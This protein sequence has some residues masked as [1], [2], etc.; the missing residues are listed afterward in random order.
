[1]MGA[2]NKGFTALE[3]MLSIALLTIIVGAVWVLADALGQ[4]SN[5]QEAVITTQGSVTGAMLKIVR[6]LRQASDASIAW[7]PDNRLTALTY[8][9]A[10]D[11]DG[12]GTAVDVGGFLELGPQRTITRD[13]NDVN[14]DGQT[15]TQL[16][17]IVNGNFREVLMNGMMIDED[18]DN[19][20]VLDGTEDTNFNQ[21]LDRG[22]LFENTATGIRV[23]LQAQRQMNPR[24]RP[25]LSTMVEVVNPRN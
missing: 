17:L 14:N 22:V 3:M 10:E 9:V 21:R 6:E 5:D 12:N 1:M 18:A 11:V 15:L 20:N 16:V 23:T 4:A 7:T 13:I 24:S 19:D 25:M 2:R 8:Q